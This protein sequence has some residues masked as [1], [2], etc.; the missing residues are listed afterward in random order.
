MKNAEE[1]LDT[2]E[3]G[4]HKTIK[5]DIKYFVTLANDTYTKRTT[6]HQHCESRE[7]SEME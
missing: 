2:L 1:S 5:Q 3:G 6:E 4:D 7:E